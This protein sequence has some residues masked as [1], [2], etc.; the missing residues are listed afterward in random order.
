VK[1]GIRSCVRRSHQPGVNVQEGEFLLAVNGRE[2]RGSDEV[3]ALFEGA[4]D[5]FDRAQG[6]SNG[7]RQKALA[8]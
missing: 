8:T 7:G 5:K 2:L 1:T 4:A 3:F 6:R